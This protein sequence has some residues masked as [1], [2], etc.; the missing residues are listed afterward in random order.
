VAA[1]AADRPASLDRQPGEPGAAAAAGD[2]A[3]PEGVSE[4]FAD[5]L[6]LTLNCAR[7]SA[8]T[9]TEHALTLTGSLRAT[10]GE[11][12][13]GRLDWPRAR[14]LSEE[15]GRPARG[16]DPAIVAAVEAAVL[17]DAASLSIRR[18]TTRIRQELA[19]RD[20]AASDRRRE[21]AQ[22]A[23]TVRRRPV[24]D[25]V[26]ELV[27]G[28]P[29]E[30]AAACQATVDELAWR[31]HRAGDARPIG[32]LRVGC[33][34]IWCCGPGWRPSRWPRPSRSRCRWGP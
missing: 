10:L 31:A 2:D 21:R 18:L 6:A 9:L 15:L 33:W 22:R 11:L 34:P 23:V 5:E 27:A 12:A 24:G 20:A 8:S 25:G 32:M 19:A 13:Q 16:T 14:T 26:S 29:D 7:A 1:F 30:L 17:P 3:A 28:M 4:F